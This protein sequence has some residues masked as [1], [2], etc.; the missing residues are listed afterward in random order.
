MAIAFTIREPWMTSTI[1]GATSMEQLKSN[2]AA[3]DLELSEEC[4]KDIHKVYQDYP[5]PF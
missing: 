3:V 5:V 1:I 4:L 2:I